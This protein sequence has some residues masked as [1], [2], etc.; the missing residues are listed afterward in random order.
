MTTHSEIFSTGRLKNYTCEGQLN[1]DDL[2]DHL[3]PEIPSEKS[4]LLENK[5]INTE[6][7]I[8]M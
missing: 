5:D 8:E 7:E 1:F 2:S 4:N 6:P 3:K